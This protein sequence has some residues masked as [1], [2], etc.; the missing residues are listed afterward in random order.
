[1]QDIELDEKP[2]WTI[3]GSVTDAWESII[4]Y[5][6]GVATPCHGEAPQMAGVCMR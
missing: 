4:F 3:T 2:T 5:G 6:A 1:M